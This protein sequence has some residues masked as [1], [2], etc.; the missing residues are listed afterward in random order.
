MCRARRAGPRRPR[1]TRELWRRGQTRQQ[2][3]VEQQGCGQPPRAALRRART[4]PW[5]SAVGAG[6]LVG[7]GRARLRDVYRVGYVNEFVCACLWMCVFMYVRV[8]GLTV[9]VRV[10]VRRRS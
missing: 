10:A 9:R 6:R 2:A 8:C 5:R 1:Q 4:I 7:A 3:Q